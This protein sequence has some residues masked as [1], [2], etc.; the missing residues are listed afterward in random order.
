[1]FYAPPHTQGAPN[2]VVVTCL[3]C[4]HTSLDALQ[5]QRMHCNLRHP[6]AMYVIVCPDRHVCCTPLTPSHTPLMQS[7]MAAACHYQIARIAQ[8]SSRHDDAVQHYKRALDEHPLLW[9]AYRELCTIGMLLVLVCSPV[10]MMCTV[11]CVLLHHICSCEY[12]P[13]S[14]TITPTC[15]LINNRS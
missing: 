2:P 9:C 7:A 3:P 5:K 12:I 10:N 13:N 4:W 6:C 11:V 15:S 8:L 14:S 1:M